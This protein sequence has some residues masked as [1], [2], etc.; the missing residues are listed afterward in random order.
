[1]KTIFFIVF[2]IFILISISLSATEIPD[3]EI[4]K[5]EKAALDRW[6]KGDVNG[7]IELSAE[8]ISYFDPSLDIRLDGRKAFKAYLEPL[9]KTF[10]IYRYEIL[11]PKVYRHGLIAVL[12]F[13]LCNYNQE[14]ATTAK[15]NS[16][17]V[18]QKIKGKWKII[19]SHWSKTNPKAE[20][21]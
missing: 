17:E 8:N 10:K 1:M 19:H 13:N 11:N 3:Q 21:E 4:L 12:C 18:Y 5:L 9:F 6:Q 2:Q 15:W 20:N 7:F 14:G 16:T